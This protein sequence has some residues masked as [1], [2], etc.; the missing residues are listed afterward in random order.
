MAA[1]LSAEEAKLYDRGIRL[2]GMSAQQRL[3]ESAVL[4]LG[5]GELGAELCKNIV[6]AGVARVVVA[7]ADPSPAHALRHGSNMFVRADDADLDAA[8]ARINELNSFVKVEGL[9]VPSWDADALRAALPTTALAQYDFVCVCDNDVPLAAAAELDS[10]CRDAGASFLDTR[11]F[12]TRALLY[13]DMPL[14]DPTAASAAAASAAASSDDDGSAAA[15]AEPTQKRARPK[16]RRALPRG[17]CY[18]DVLAL[19]EADCDVLRVPP[20]LRTVQAMARGEEPAEK[21]LGEAYRGRSA[22]AFVC[23]VVGGVASQEVVKELIRD[24]STPEEQQQQEK[25]E[26]QPLTT[27]EQRKRQLARKQ[28]SESAGR[29]LCN[30]LCYDCVAGTGTVV[31]AAHEEAQRVLQAAHNAAAQEATEIL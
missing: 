29:P 22:L 3:R 5:V 16:Y 30:V 24:H 23:A 31:Y 19:P 27:E 14:F 4:V 25:Q 15:A 1:T 12:G 2:W 6:L 21:A 28:Q 18:A 8:L 26:K 11:L 13:C 9:H 10:R 7:F 20:L 17:P